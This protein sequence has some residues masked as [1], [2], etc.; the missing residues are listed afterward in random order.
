MSD[1]QVQVS[2]REIIDQC[3][4][5]AMSLSDP[6]LDALRAARESMLQRS[7]RRLPALLVTFAIELMVAFVITT[8]RRSPRW[9]HGDV[10]PRRM[11]LT[12]LSP[13]PNALAVH[14]QPRRPLLIAFMPVF[15][16]ISGNIGLQS[17]PPSTP[18][19]LALGLITANQPVGV[20]RRRFAR[21]E[22][23]SHTRSR[24][25][26]P[27]R[28][29]VPQLPRPSHCHSSGRRWAF[30]C[31]AP[32]WSPVRLGYD[33]TAL[34]GPLETAFQTEDVCGNI[35]FLSLA[36]FILG[37]NH[38]VAECEGGVKVMNAGFKFFL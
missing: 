31:F 18:A 33:P 6:R 10:C 29:R 7:R 8:A 28:L 20:E 34:A 38:G 19:A 36:S 32:C 24:L 14:Q 27:C 12:H 4:L 5:K 11:P 16:A 37:W 35:L 15:S 23:R 22:G 9:S 26:P 17:S 21:V 3:D 1:K 30:R 25:R 2:E 13:I